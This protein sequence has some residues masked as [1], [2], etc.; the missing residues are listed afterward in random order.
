MTEEIKRIVQ[1]KLEHWEKEF[2]IKNRSFNI[3]EEI[4]IIQTEIIMHIA[5]GQDANDVKLPYI[6]KS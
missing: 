4:N 2:E 1:S 6:Y 5:F 3:V